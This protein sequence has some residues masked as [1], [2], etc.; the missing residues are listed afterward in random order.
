MLQDYYQQAQKREEMGIPPLPLNATQTSELCELL[1]HP[2]TGKEG[3]LKDSS[4][5]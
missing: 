2:P 3:E 5:V 1:E 4:R